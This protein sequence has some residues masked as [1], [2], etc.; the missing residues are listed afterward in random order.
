MPQKYSERPLFVAKSSV[1]ALLRFYMLSSFYITI[2]LVLLIWWTKYSAG[3]AVINTPIGK[4]SGGKVVLT[5][6]IWIAL[7]IQFLRRLIACIKRFR[8]YELSHIRITSRNMRYIQCEDIRI[9][10]LFVNQGVIDI[11]LEKITRKSYMSMFPDYGTLTLGNDSTLLVREYMYMPQDVLNIIT[12]SKD[13]YC[14]ETGTI[15]NIHL[16]KSMVKSNTMLG[17]KLD[18]MVTIMENV[19]GQVRL[20]HEETKKIETKGNQGCQT[21]LNTTIYK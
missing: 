2:T 21:I 4:W 8:L 14:Y 19:S 17:S 9:F 7:S 16:E 18:N 5:T 13:T 11:P 20:E 3:V 10:R 6:G 15:G 1:N 12:E